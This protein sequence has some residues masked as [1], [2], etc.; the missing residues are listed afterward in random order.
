[1]CTFLILCCTVLGVTV[2]DEPSRRLLA[3]EGMD[4][5]TAA[6]F[7][8]SGKTLAIGTFESLFV[9]KDQKFVD[10]ATVRLYDTSNGKVSRKLLS[11]SAWLIWPTAISP[12]ENWLLAHS[13]VGAN[14]EELQLWDVNGGKCVWKLPYEFYGAAC[15]SGDSKLFFHALEGKRK[16]SEEKFGPGSIVARETSSLKTVFVLEGHEFGLASLAVSN[17]NKL[18]AVGGSGGRICIWDLAKR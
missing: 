1:M 18:L 12:D 13:Q 17:E 5:F 11:D 2:T 14:S 7:S 15:F 4:D 10:F 3:L 6:V 8:P 9:E 16:S